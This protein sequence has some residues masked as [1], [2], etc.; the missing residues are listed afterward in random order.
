VVFTGAL[1]PMV[2]ARPGDA[3][4]AHIEGLGEVQA[5]FA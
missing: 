1:G 3:Y 4:R 2:A 5:L